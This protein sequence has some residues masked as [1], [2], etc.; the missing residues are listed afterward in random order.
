MYAD[1]GRSVF[2][3]DGT[4]VFEAGIQDSNAYFYFG[5]TSVAQKL[6]AALA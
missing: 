1:I 3:P 5:D 2:A 4:L 6:C